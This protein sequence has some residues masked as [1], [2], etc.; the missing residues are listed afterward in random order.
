MTR[1]GQISRRNLFRRSLGIRTPENDG[2]PKGQPDG[3]EPIEILPEPVAVQDATPEKILKRINAEPAYRLVLPRLLAFCFEPRSAGEIHEELMCFSVMRTAAHTPKMLL[4]WMI[5]TGAVARYMEEDSEKG[6]KDARW[7]TTEAGIEAIAGRDPAER[8]RRLLDEE[9]EY[10]DIYRMILEFCS[11]ERSI[12]EIEY[13]LRAHPALENP[14]VYPSYLVDRLEFTGA[15][16][17][18]GKWR[19]AETGKCAQGNTD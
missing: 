8:L 2:E 17:W 15:L 19:A 11:C 7:L 10:S 1:N 16:E 6:S 9:P 4:A 5:E 13:L 3:F 18:T 14:K 12:S